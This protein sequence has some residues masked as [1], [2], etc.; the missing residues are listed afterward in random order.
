MKYA[1]LCIHIFLF[2]F[3]SAM[4]MEIAKQKQPYYDP[5]VDKLFR[6]SETYGIL[7]GANTKLY[8]ENQ[9][10]KAKLFRVNLALG[11]ADERIKSYIEEQKKFDHQRE[12]DKKFRSLRE[13]IENSFTETIKNLQK[14]LLQSQETI[15]LLNQENESLSQQLENIHKSLREK[16]LAKRK[17]FLSFIGLGALQ[18]GFLFGIKWLYH[19]FMI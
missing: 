6:N 8:T 16:A 13:I 10:L 3:S 1:F 4:G 19:H 2:T 15:E 5:L 14:D 12:L 11:A 17:A 7:F 18:V 9:M